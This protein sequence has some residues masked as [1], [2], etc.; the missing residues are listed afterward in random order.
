MGFVIGVRVRDKKL[1]LSGLKSECIGI[2]VAVITGFFFGLC[3][4]WSETKWGSSESF[5]TEE[6]RTR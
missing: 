3:T 2:A 4:T 1:W 6:M 5:P